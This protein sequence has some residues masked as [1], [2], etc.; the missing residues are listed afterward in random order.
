MAYGTMVLRSCGLGAASR[1][2][3]AQ[4]PSK[5]GPGGVRRRCLRWRW[6]SWAVATATGEIPYQVAGDELAVAEPTGKNA[7]QGGL[8]GDWTLPSFGE[9]ARGPI[10]RAEGAEVFSGRP[11]VQRDQ[12]AWA[13]RCAP[14][15]SD[16]GSGS[17]SAS[18]AGRG[19]NAHGPGQ[20]ER[21]GPSRVPR[22]CWRWSTP[23]LGGPSR[24]SPSGT[25]CCAAQR[26]HARAGAGYTAEPV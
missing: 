13:I 25:S 4:M 19:G 22:S 1:G 10:C 26:D 11:D 2:L 5:H 15:A 8:I 24:R 14:C 6:R 18:G 20:P 3:D 12:S 16:A 7:V 17:R 23:G 9:I 21:L